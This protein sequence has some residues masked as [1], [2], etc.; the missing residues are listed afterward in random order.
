M[1]DLLTL[2]HVRAA[3]ARIRDSIVETPT[4]HSQTLSKLT[5]ANIYLKFEN[6]QFTAAY[7]ERGALNAILLLSEE[8]R[9]KG[10]IAASAGNHAQGLSYHGT[11]LGIPVTIVMP[12]PTPTVKVMQTESVGGKVVLFGETFDDAYKYARQLEAEQGLTFVHPFDD[13]NVAAGQGTVALEMLESIPSLDMLVVPIGGGGLLSGM[14]TAARALKPDIGLI[15]VQAELYPSMYALL[16]NVEMP[17]E[18]DTLA[19]GIAVKIPGAFTSEVIR[20][21]VDEIVLVSEA[22]LETAVSLLLQ[23]E[24]TVVEGAGAAGLAAV[25]ANPE[26]FAGK[27]VGI[28]LCGGNIDTRLLANVL[29]R[30][31]ARSGRLARLR[32]TLQDRPGALFKVMRL[33]NEHNI[34]II[35]IYHQRIFT[36]LPAKGLIT[37]IECEARDAQQ[38][39]G[40]VD[41]LNVAG[42]KVERVELNK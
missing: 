34:N 16:K 11:R 33:F 3:H 41:G 31:L 38:L 27:N 35:E 18:G 1:S 14:G 20:E 23:I 7:K 36:T 25:M 6:L 42:Y 21:L 17:C 4:L 39:Q 29:L 24:K 15:G 32:L 10:V 12:V 26:I 30:D 2:D 13:P 22:E 9:S 37:D 19:E 8:Q 28:V 40:L 5:G